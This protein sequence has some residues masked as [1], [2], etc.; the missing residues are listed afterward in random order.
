MGNLFVNQVLAEDV[1]A[2]PLTRVDCNKAG[3]TW[4]D[5]ANV[6]GAASLAGADQLEAQGAQRV[7]VQPLTR[8]SCDKTG[9]TWDH[10]ANVCGA[11]SLAAEEQPD[12]LEETSPRIL[13]N[14]DKGG[15]KMTVLLDGVQQYE[16][17]ISDCGGTQR[18]RELTP[19]DR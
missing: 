12:A 9:M 15:Q 11:A 10:T 2:Q 18:L 6:C 16:W 5:T 13:I 1:S 4:D 19:P 3:M 14:I 7:V 17:P 8:E